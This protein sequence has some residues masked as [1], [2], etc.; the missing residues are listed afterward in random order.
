MGAGVVPERREVEQQSC[1]ICG[2]GTGAE[3][4]Q[5]EWNERVRGETATQQVDRNYVELLQEVRVAQTGVQILFAFLLGLAFTQRFDALD[6]AQRAVYV[7]TLTLSAAAAGVLLAPVMYHRLVF[8]RRLKPHVVITAH[9]LAIAGLVLVLLAM[10]G[11]VQLAVSLI[12]GVGASMLATV[13]GL[14][15]SFLWFGLPWLD[16]R[17]HDH[18]ESHR[19]RAFS[20]GRRPRDRSEPEDR[21]RIPN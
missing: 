3:S 19:S 17:R 13:I 12:L 9:R 8:R 2:S 21:L 11:S 16:L 1:S 20:A 10:V 5:Q 4:A 15:L 7:V 18:E 6:A 14:A